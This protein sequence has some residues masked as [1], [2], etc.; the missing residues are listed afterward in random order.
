MNPFRNMA[1]CALRISRAEAD[2]HPDYGNATG[3]L[4]FVGGIMSVAHEITTQDIAAIFEV[5]GCRNPLINVPA[6]TI[7][8]GANPTIT[9]G[10]SDPRLDEIL[11]VG[12]LI[13]EAADPVGHS[14]PTLVGCENPTDT[15]VIVEYW[16]QRWDCGVL[17]DPPYKRTIL[18]LVQATPQGYTNENGLAQIPF[19]GVGR[20]NANFENGPFADLDALNDGRDP[21]AVAHIYDDTL[22]T[23]EDP[24]DYTALPATS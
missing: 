22:P 18:P 2:G 5:D 13:T 23:E 9:M 16:S 21:W 14:V 4:T 17:A 15:F 12:D 3:A 24:F 19:T 6:K 1:V 7:V 11:G 20:P 8:T 10:R